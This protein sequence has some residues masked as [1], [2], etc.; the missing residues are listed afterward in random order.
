MAF[1]GS[2]RVAEYSR[3]TDVL[4]KNHQTFFSYRAGNLIDNDRKV[5]V[6][7]QLVKH[8]KY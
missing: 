4:E 7:R 8:L 3:G 6:G 1:V 2:L 5:A